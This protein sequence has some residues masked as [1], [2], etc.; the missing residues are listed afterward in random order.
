MQR[1]LLAALSGE[2]LSRAPDDYIVDYFDRFAKDFDTQLVEVL[3]Y[4]VP[5]NLHALLEATGRT[6]PCIL[7]AG[8]GTGLAGPLL[9]SLGTTTLSGVDLAPA[10]L[11]K[12]SER[13]VYDH[14]VEGNI[15]TFLQQSKERY[16]LVLAADV[17]IYVGELTALMPLVAKSLEPGG[18]FAL[19]I[20][21]TDAADLVL[22]PSGRFAHRMSYIEELSKDDFIVLQA[23]PTTIRLEANQPV[24]GVLVLLQRR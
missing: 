2:P 20:E 12:A 1:Y 8:C 15:L 11:K 7:D 23:V 13:Q 16:D 22:L 10:M 4:R 24:A 3:G 18:L 5:E 9:R 21:T 6:F 19:S 17:L 14:L